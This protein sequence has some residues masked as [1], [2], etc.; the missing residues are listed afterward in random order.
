MWNGASVVVRATADP[1]SEDHTDGYLFHKGELGV[2][3]F[4]L[5]TE[6]NDM[7]LK[8]YVTWDKDTWRKSRDVSPRY[9]EVVGLQTEDGKR[10]QVPEKTR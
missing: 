6:D 10:I 4:G 2:I 8:A 3:E 7:L 1:L 5:A 9:F